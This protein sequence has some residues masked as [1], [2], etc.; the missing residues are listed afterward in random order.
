MQEIIKSDLRDQKWYGRLVKDCRDIIVEKGFRARMEVIEGY[1]ALGERIETDVDFKKWSNLRGEAI[2]QLA[3]DIKLSKE[4][5]YSA[6]QFYNKYPEL[7][8]ALQ[9]FEEG[10]N[11]S[12]FKIVNKYLSQPRKEIVPL[13]EGKW[14]V[15]YADPPWEYGDKGGYVA[16][17]LQ[18]PTMNIGELC[19]MKVRDI[20]ADNAVLF[21]WVTV[22]I[23]PECFPVVEDW[24][25][26]YRSL[27]VWDKMAY[28]WGH[29][30]FI[31]CELLLLCIKGSF[32]IQN[33]EMEQN[34]KAIKRTGVHSEKPEYFRGLI[35]RMYPGG[36]K[37]ELFARNYHKGWTSWGDEI[38]IIKEEEGVNI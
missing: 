36:K 5:L 10:I 25:F 37:I 32:P 29:Y 8:Y 2:R 34:I 35:E 3:Y 19:K 38:Q 27:I 31:Q 33:E 28:N 16:V 30:W 22:P 1:H 11:I 7:S 12:W 24:G 15:L 23:L 21:L 6:I 13:P 9:S 14:D 26:K 4:T 20:T 18:Y 17:D